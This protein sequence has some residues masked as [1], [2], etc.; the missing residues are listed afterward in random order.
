MSEILEYFLINDKKF[1]LIIPPE[2]IED[3]VISLAEKINNDYKNT[4][5]LFLLVL[6][7]SYVF[8]A[9]LLRKINLDCQV[10]VVMAKSYGNELNSSG[11]VN[12]SI[13]KTEIKDRDVIIIEDIVDS[14]LTLQTLINKLKK[15]Q[16]ASLETAALLSKPDKRS[17]DV[18]VKYIGM[19]ISGEFV[20]G[21]GL[22]YAEHG[23]QLP[24]IYKLVGE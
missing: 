12:L 2:E 20:I 22:D 11:V 14:G 7:G 18:K 5:P 15:Q 3:A 17:V 13:T 10:D 8:A 16:P 19:E 4:R 9:D 21:Y 24:G 1:K 23:R 6:K